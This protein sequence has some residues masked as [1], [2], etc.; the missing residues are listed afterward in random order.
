MPNL[1]GFGRFD[2]RQNW[3]YICIPSKRMYEKSEQSELLRL[4]IQSEQSELWKYMHDFFFLAQTEA[5]SHTVFPCLPSPT[6]LFVWKLRGSEIHKS[7]IPFSTCLILGNSVCATSARTQL[8]FSVASSGYSLSYFS[9]QL[10]VM[11]RF[12]EAH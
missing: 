12:R 10:K 2:I 8:D 3:S 11:H 1:K 4:F 7:F 9:H 6:S 5:T